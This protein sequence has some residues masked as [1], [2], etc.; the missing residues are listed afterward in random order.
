MGYCPEAIAARLNREGVPVF[1][2]GVR[3]YKTYIIDLLSNGTVIGTM[4]PHRKLRVGSK[5]LNI[6]LEPVKDYYPAIIPKKVY[7][8]VQQIHSKCQIPTT[9]RINILNSV[10][11]CTICG[12]IMK[13]TAKIKNRLRYLKCTTAVNGKSCGQKHFP[14]K[15]LESV[16]IN[17][18][19]ESLLSFPVANDQS[20]KVDVQL[21]DEHLKLK[22]LKAYKVSI[23][24]DIDNIDNS[25]SQRNATLV[26]ELLIQLRDIKKIERHI[27][28]ILIDH[29]ETSIDMVDVIRKELFDEINN[30]RP[31]IKRLNFLI[32]GLFSKVELYK[33]DKR[34][35]RF[36]VT[37]KAGPVLECHYDD[38][39]YQWKYL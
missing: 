12:S 32:R 37:Y 7:D 11:I 18:L 35:V 23:L 38:N 13:S 29:K 3:W 34:N 20:T 36:V 10:A 6:P 19:C 17:V 22:E 1:R 14:Y 24:K 26:H 25:Y 30:K 4:T 15:R 9:V 5:V 27:S 8:R 31:S 28:N 33:E 2:R 39:S 21:I 16:F